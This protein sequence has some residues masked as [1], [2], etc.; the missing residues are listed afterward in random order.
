MM[1]DWWHIPL[2]P[3]LF[4]LLMMR[5]PSVSNWIWLAPLPGL[6]L[7][8]HGPANIELPMLWPGAALGIDSPVNHYFLL[9]SIVLWSIASLFASV[10]QR[11]D[12]H[13]L[14]F[15]SFWLWSMTGNL[16]LVIALDPASFYVGFTLMSLAAYGLVAHQPGPL[17]RQAGRLYLQ[18]AV[19]GEMLIYAGL[20]L[21]VHETGGLLSFSDWQQ[22][23]GWLTAVC[24]LTGFGLKAGFWPLHLW[25]PLAHPVA[26]T[27]ASAVLSGAM[28][29]AGILGIWQFIPADTPTTVALG[30]VVFF[31]GL[32][33]AFYAVVAGLLQQQAKTVLAFSSVSQM[34]Y[35][36]MIIA[37]FWMTG[38]AT[39]SLIILLAM[40][41]LHHAVAKAALFMGA[42]LASSRRLSPWHWGLMTL[43][44]LA[45]AGLPLTTG[46]SVKYL[47]KDAVSDSM[48]ALSL[49]LLSIGSMATALLL[50]RALLLMKQSQ[51][52]IS[53]NAGAPEAVALSSW[54][55]LSLAP[56]VI[57]LMVDE[58][59][60]QLTQTMQ[61]QALTGLLWPI[62]LATVIA[63]I[64]SRLSL[65]T[66][67]K[68]K[69]FAGRW[70]SL[71]LRYCL[72]HF[73]VPEWV[74]RLKLDGW[75]KVE[76]SINKFSSVG[77]LPITIGLTFLMMLSWTMLF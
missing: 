48:F 8:W 28:L 41:G 33:G 32:F 18:L 20:I 65:K 31:I 38:D 23:I 75:R 17:P 60:H 10:K 1:L 61:L 22:P 21:R 55:V 37:M 3:L 4:W 16:L 39:S 25:L 15:W 62:I 49:P 52:N 19:L 42:G 11:N 7:L 5:W 54:L 69:L 26:P 24:L 51:Q 74:I 57:P 67:F 50:I 58:F 6:F 27:A 47:F 59:R 9:L 13:R 40:Y 70:L 36:L 66:S 30:P 46:A 56:I 64:V 68:A 63:A 43:P 34:G 71:R 12:V 44:A 76:R 53:K 72:I 35:L 2:I 77:T 29:K 14:R 45:L 73:P